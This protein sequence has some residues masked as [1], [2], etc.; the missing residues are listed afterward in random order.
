MAVKKIISGE[1]VVPSGAIA[2]PASLEQFK[3]IEALYI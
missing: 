1:T 2:N 3:T